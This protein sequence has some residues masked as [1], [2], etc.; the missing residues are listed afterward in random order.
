M[1][2]DVWYV[3]G[4]GGLGVETMDILQNAIH[5]GSQQPHRLAFLVD[6]P[7]RDEA[8]GLPVVTVGRH[9]VGAKVTIAVGE[10]TH[11]LLML[12]K[13]T[14]LGLKPS[15]IISPVAFVSAHAKIGVGTIV[16][17]H[18]S[19][20]STAR[21]GR[22]VAINTGT[23]IGHDVI[24]GDNC[25]LSS[26]V[27]LGGGV[28]VEKLGYIGMGALI[29]EKLRI[30]HTSIV[31]M[32]SVVYSDVPEEVIALGNPARVMRRNVDMKVFK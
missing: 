6:T 28:H 12:E 24:V 4:A 15:S 13:V 18:C 25:V 10:P 5:V 27:N 11:R 20:Q 9:V 8:I 31:G 3:Y 29:K 21:I 32:G 19:I 26:M 23:I 17:P 7:N 30:G 14:A 22:N 16:A 1:T 2:G